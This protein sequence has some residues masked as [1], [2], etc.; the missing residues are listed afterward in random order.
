MSARRWSAIPLLG[1]V[2]LPAFAV[3][4]TLGA[5]SPRAQ[6]P[7]SFDRALLDRYCVS[8]HGPRQRAAGLVLTELDPAHVDRDARIWE[9]VVER[10]RGGTMPPAGMPRP[11][12]AAGRAFAESVEAALDR[13]AADAPSPGRTVLR[14]L[15]RVEYAN[16]IQDLLDLDIDAQSLFPADKSFDGFDNAGAALS[17]S[18]ALMERYLSAARRISRLAVGSPDIG[19]A[20][21]AATYEAPQDLW[22]SSRIDEDAPFGSR[23]GLSI[24]HRFPLDA[25]YLV[26]I[27]LRRN[28]LGYV[29]GLGE[30]HALDVRLDGTRVARVAV[31]GEHKG[32]PAPLSFSGVIAGDAAWEAYAV[33]ADQNLVVSVPVKAGTR[34][35]NV[36]FADELW[37]EEGVQQPPLTGLGFSYDESRTAPTGPWGPAVESIT[38]DGPYRATGAGQT[39]SRTRLFA[40][41]PAPDD[42]AGPCART[43]LSSL[44]RRAYRRAI[45]DEDLQPL[46]A[47]FRAGLER[48][49]FDEG[50]RAAVERVLVDPS[51]L[52]RLERD[53]QAVAPGVAYRVSDVELASRL[54]FFL[55]SSIPDGALLDEAIAGR[56]HEPDHLAA[57]VRRMLADRRASMLGDNFAVQWLALRR[58]NDAA[59]DPDLFP[60]FDGNLRQAFDR[61]TRLFVGD[62]MRRDQSVLALLD[63]DYTFVNERLAR[64]YGIPDVHGNQF[65]RVALTDRTRAG[66]LGQGSILTLTSLPTRT[67]PV[68]RGRW[69]LDTLFGMPT[70][71]P[72]PDIPEFPP[73]HSDAGLLSVRQRT[74]RHR[75]NP[76]CASCHARM[77][78][79]G[80]ALENFD[81][82]GRWRASESGQAIDASGS[83][84]DGTHFSGVD[85]LRL[86]I[87]SQPDGF[88]R[89]TAGKLLAYAIGRGLEPSDAPAIRRIV[90]ESAGGGYRWSAMIEGV[91]R[92]APFLMRK[93]AS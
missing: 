73:S 27:H 8:C 39:P 85:E 32:M 58:L 12:P 19:P 49:G 16:A 90:R 77:D 93:T 10:L 88:L 38:I 36:S 28:I 9:Q 18:P 60:E 41:Q 7:L 15:T 21:A 1:L 68:L 82:I 25:E 33:S 53:P 71:P 57:Q 69:V 17:T 66:L 35:L 47:V 26:R 67:S 44:A 11:E 56:L 4:V 92:S 22:Q 63:A 48:G 84:P 83:L 55:W 72:P 23:G 42:N 76:A 91:V 20:F 86:A 3:L 65:R 46:I 80:F 79:L 51:F 30:A 29:R 64:H 31:G 52:F 61:E 81:A 78:P 59:P 13:A 74:E 40:C 89:A 50:I 87:L 62:E 24:R 70:P 6:T 14:R 43:I 5:S 45:T 75:T 37:V 54:S 34:A 2:I